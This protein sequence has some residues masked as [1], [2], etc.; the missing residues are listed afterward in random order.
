MRTRLLAPDSFL[1]L[2]TSL[3]D[4]SLLR[5]EPGGEEQTRFF[6]LDLVRSYALEQLE[7]RGEGDAVRRRHAGAFARLVAEAEPDA[8]SARQAF[9]WKAFNADIHN[10]RAALDWAVNTGAA[11]MAAE[12]CAGLRHFWITQNYLQEAWCWIERTLAAVADH[13][14]SL[15][16][17]LAAR[18]CTMLRAASLS[19]ATINRRRGHS[20][21]LLSAK[22]GLRAM[23]AAWPTRSMG[24]PWSPPPVVVTW[25]HRRF[26]SKVLPF[27][28]RS[29]TT[30]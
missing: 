16:P 12:M 28:G 13:E 26:R 23:S 24:W 6:M 3:V 29:A 20:S 1:Q 11:E 22:P 17:L 15:S 10:L 2:V 14:E 21:T 27:R 25:S 8:H 9:W 4:K 18:A 30:G 7:A 19:I 5:V